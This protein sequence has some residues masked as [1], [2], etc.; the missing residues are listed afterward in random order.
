MG[1][2]GQGLGQIRGGWGAE[3]SALLQ[4]RGS[5]P[6]APAL[7]AAPLPPGEEGSLLR[8]PTSAFFWPCSLGHPETQRFGLGLRGTGDAGGFLLL[9]R[10]AMG[11]VALR[12]R[13]LCL[14]EPW[15]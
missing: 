2:G 5:P 15:G 1:G 7:L 8:K 9:A 11:K 4:L 14:R 12:S 13:G 10:K 6:S 3:A